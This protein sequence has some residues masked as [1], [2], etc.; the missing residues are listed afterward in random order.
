M[1]ASPQLLAE[2]RG[3]A[4]PG[5]EP[6]GRF[7]ISEAEARRLLAAPN[8]HGKP[9]SDV[10]R[11]WAGAA[12]LRGT[13]RRRWIIDFPPDMDEREAPL[14]AQPYARVRRLVRPVW[15]GRRTRW[16]VHGRPQPEM[17]I[18]LAKHD[19][20]IATPAAGRARIFAWL[21][22]DWLPAHSLVVF[23]HD[24]DWFLGVLHS[25]A[26]GVWTRAAGRY[27]PAACFD[28]FP[29]P[30]PPTTPLSKL[31]RVQDEQ[32]T[33]IAFAARTL[34]VQRRAWLEAEEVA[35]PTLSALYR[36]E[37]PWLDELHAR[38]DAAVAAAYGWPPGISDQEIT[39]RLTV[40][41]RER[42]GPA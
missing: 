26:H 31:T 34:D 14:Y 21:P 15:G 6:R 2:N 1:I 19:R 13:P 11:P 17:R 24:D 16:W 33:A 27:T 3:V 23:A 29:F 39:S 8:R 22:P 37:P 20:F 18:A 32:R 4:F 35:A 7:E 28:T 9:N 5:D 41:N 36:L 38:L 25:R 40:L 42:A 12:D 10:V 30:W